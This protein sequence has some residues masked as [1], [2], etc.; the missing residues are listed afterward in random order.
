M[1]IGILTYHRSNNYGALLQAIALRKVLADMGHEVSFIDYWPA[2]HR[3]IYEAFSIASLKYRSLK[4]NYNYIKYCIKNYIWRKKRIKRFEEFINHYIVPYLSS[5]NDSYDIIVH[6]SDQIWRKQF[7]IRVYNPIYFGKHNITAK[8]KISYAASMGVIAETEEDKSL[9]KS[10]LFN[11]DR[12]SV[13]EENL[14]N[15]VQELGFDCE[16]HIDPV[17]L[18][19]KEQW[20]SL[21]PMTK[22]FNDK[23]ILYYCLQPNA[24][25]ISEIN[26]FAEYR[27]LKVITI[28]GKVF[29]KDTINEIAIAN[30]QDLLNLIRGT[31]FVFTSSFHGLAFSLI[32]QK[33][34]YAS[35]NRNSV[36]AES[37]LSQLGLS[38]Y[39]LEQQSVIPLDY[40]EFNYSMIENKISKM[41]ERSYKYLQDSTIM[42][43]NY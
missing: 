27:G 19:N 42:Y 25:D 22:T 36:R 39:L 12:I 29:K 7:E 6:G 28:Y 20:N 4:G 37:L 21:V 23:Y 34:F 26:K 43:D 30:S 38:Q 31:E 13:R 17:F 32:F 41:R 35:F 2:Y 9:I 15:L 1:K 10:Y 11:L 18:L 40:K 5:V 14:K 16:L 24:F 33:P 3:H 8:R